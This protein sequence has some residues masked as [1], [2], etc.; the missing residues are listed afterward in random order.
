[1]TVYIDDMQRRARVGRLTA[2]WSHLMAD[3]SEELHA[4]AARLGMR[5]SWAQH[6]GKPLEH[7]DVT[8]PKRQLALQLGAVPIQY[9]R[10]GGNLTLA[11]G[12]GQTFDLEGFRAGTWV[13]ATERSEG[14]GVTT[15][16]LLNAL[17]GVA[18]PHGLITV[19]T[20]NFL[21]KLDPALIRAGRMDRIE[22]IDMPTPAVVNEMF[23][24]FYGSPPPS[25]MPAPLLSQAGIAEVF[26]RHFGDP[27][28]A[29]DELM[30]ERR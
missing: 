11:K 20:T 12:R 10:E 4:F 19:M 5:R 9:G 2:T 27:L 30:L 23:E 6:E 21:E 22:H 7:Y 3:T 25:E 14:V 15:G 17:D 8:E 18:T 26:K 16:S 1:M 28:G 13:V 24:H 29:W